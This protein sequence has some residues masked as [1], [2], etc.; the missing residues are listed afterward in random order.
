MDSNKI[1]A[2]LPEFYLT[3]LYP[4][5]MSIYGDM[6][7]ILAFQRKLERLGFSVKY[8][9]VSPGG[10][11]PKQT[12]F[13]FIGGGQDNEQYYIFKD[14]LKK[15]EKLLKDLEFGTPLLAIC[16]GYQLLG[17]KFVDGEGREIDGIGFFDVQTKSPDDTVKSRCIGNVSAK[18]THP[19]FK[20]VSL[21]GFENHG[22]QTYF[23]SQTE[24]NEDQKSKP[25]AKIVNGFGNNSVE[26]L[27]GCYKKN[28]IGT[29]LHG[30]CLPKNPELTN[31][32]IKQSLKIKSRK[33]KQNYESFYDTSR[34]NDEIAKKVNQTLTHL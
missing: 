31:W 27:E 3:H 12:D 33:E 25:L 4:E 16:G 24:K 10:S 32:L 28:A 23:L 14:L 21:V 20:N 13:Y 34:W 9:Q 26:K 2:N 11:L 29:Y 19:G 17:K 22:G 15:K 30:S 5:Q 7:N 6:G 8:Q 1:L 18:S